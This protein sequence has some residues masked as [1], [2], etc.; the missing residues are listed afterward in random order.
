MQKKHSDIKNFTDFEGYEMRYSFGSRY[1][2]QE[3]GD[4]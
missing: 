4:V 2:L 3:L 1:K